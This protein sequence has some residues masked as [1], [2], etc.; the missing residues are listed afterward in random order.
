[1][2]TFLETMVAL[3]MTFVNLNG[4][5]ATTTGEYYEPVAVRF[6]KSSNTTYAVWARYYVQAYNAGTVSLG[7]QVRPYPGVVQISD[8]LKD[9][10]ERADSYIQT[11]TSIK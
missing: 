4:F 2:N 7:F 10:D 3:M 9:G 1:M 6:D 11:I 5:T 8:L